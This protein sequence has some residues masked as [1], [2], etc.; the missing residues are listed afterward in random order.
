MRTQWMNAQLD[1]KS[2]YHPERSY[3]TFVFPKQSLLRTTTQDL[4]VRALP[5][6]HCRDTLFLGG[7][8]VQLDLL[9]HF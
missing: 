7:R 3:S 4:S 6:L 9:V 2:E 1:N 5:L 8:L